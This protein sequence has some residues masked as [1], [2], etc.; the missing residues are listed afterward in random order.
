MSPE[1]RAPNW[2]I[3]MSTH[4]PFAKENHLVKLRVQGR[5]RMLCV[6]WGEPQRLPGKS[7]YRQ[8]VTLEPSGVKMYELIR[9]VFQ[10]ALAPGTSPLK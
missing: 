1:A 3:G 8:G 9:K 5:R 6:Q 10:T 2:L 7:G 4:I